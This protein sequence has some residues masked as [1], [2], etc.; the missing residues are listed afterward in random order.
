MGRY[1]PKTYNNRRILRIIVRTIISVV[2]VSVILFILL[3]FGLRQYEVPVEGG[4]IRLE[5]PFL[6]DDPSAAEEGTSSSL[7]GFI[8]GAITGFIQYRLLSRLPGIVASGVFNRK[9]ALIA[10]A[11]LLS[12]PVV[13]LLIA[14]LLRGSLLWTVIGIFLSLGVLALR[15]F[16]RA[17]RK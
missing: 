2:F 17:N 16:I 5:I 11:Q 1:V 15:Q 10:I 4:G 13:I 6:M 8:L 9:T 12:P 14:Y 7:L 3:F